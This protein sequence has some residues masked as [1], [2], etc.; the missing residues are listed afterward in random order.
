[1]SSERL[2]E[3]DI[4]TPQKIIFSGTCF[5]VSLPGAQSPFQVLYNHAAIVSALDIG[6]IKIVNNDNTQIYYATE[7]G[8]AEVLHNKVSVVVETAEV[9]S[10]IDADSALSIVSSLKTQLENT[11]AIGQ[12][13]ELKRLIAIQENRIRVSKKQ[14]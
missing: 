6:A 10:V 11:Q 13:E 1:M 3:I 5:A 9:S 12:R 8:F 2:L 7:G 14:D 4:V